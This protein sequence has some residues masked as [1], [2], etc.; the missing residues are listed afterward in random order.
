[1]KKRKIG[2]GVIGMGW[3]GVVHSRAYRMLPDRFPD[4]P[5]EPE[6]L[7]C[8]DAVEERAHRAQQ[9]CGFARCT[10]DWREILEDGDVEVVNIATPNH[11][12]LEIAT[13]AAA[14]GK[15]I[16]CEKPV[17]RS[18]Q[19]TAAIERVARDEGVLTFVG[20]NYRWAPAVQRIRALIREGKLGELTH[21]RGRL[22]VGYASN[23]HSVL[24]WRLQAELAGMGAL[25]DLMSHA[26]DTAGMLAG[27]ISRVVGQRQIFIKERP[28]STP[29]QG[30]HYSLKSGGPL[31]AVTNEDYVGA[32]VQ[33]ENGVYGNLEVCRVIQG[34]RSEIGFD[35]HGTRGAVRWDFERM[36]EFEL[37]LVDDGDDR[38]YRRVLAGPEHP[39]HANFSPG[40]GIG[41]GYDDLKVIEAHQFLQSVARQEQGEPGFAEALAVAQV[42]AAILRSWE[43]ER[44]EEVEKIAH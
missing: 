18:P 31:G 36:N 24:S 14:A 8:A 42:Q 12:H 21:Y 43:T 2:V 41:L 3:M 34:P 37:Y 44:W 33:F 19:E 6:L 38:G 40:A 30:D 25:G 9:Q 26:L 16:L 5:V 10:T 23:P 15:H 17:G 7:V 28:L 35:V 39:F 27:P 1:M 11:L 32:L 29:G 22:F 4:C 20:F 13:A